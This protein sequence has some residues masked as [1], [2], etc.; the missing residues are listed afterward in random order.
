MRSPAAADQ[1]SFCST[2]PVQES[3]GFAEDVDPGGHGYA[4][5]LDAEAEIVAQDGASNLQGAGDVV[6]KEQ[7]A[8]PAPTATAPGEICVARTVSVHEEDNVDANENNSEV[9]ARGAVCA[10]VDSGQTTNFSV[11]ENRNENVTGVTSRKHSKEQPEVEMKNRKQAERHASGSLEDAPPSSSESRTTRNCA[12]QAGLEREQ[13]QPAPAS[14]CALEEQE[15][16]AAG[17]DTIEYPPSNASSK[18]NT[19]ATAAGI[20]P[21]G[22]SGSSVLPAGTVSVQLEGGSLAQNLPAGE[23]TRIPQT[24]LFPPSPGRVAL[25]ARNECREEEDQTDRT[26]NTSREPPSASP[27][28]SH[29]A[30]RNSSRTNTYF[31]KACPQQQG[32]HQVSA[33]NA[34]AGGQGGW[35][36]LMRELKRHEN[37]LEPYL[38]NVAPP[39]PQVSCG[40]L[41]TMGGP[42]CKLAGSVAPGSMAISRKPLFSSNAKR[43]HMLGDYDHDH[44]NSRTTKAPRSPLLDPKLY[45]ENIILRSTLRVPPTSA[46]EQGTITHHVQAESAR[47]EDAEQSTDIIQEFLGEAAVERG[48]A[49]GSTSQQKIHARASDPAMKNNMQ[50]DDATARAPS[51]P[52]DANPNTSSKG[53]HS[54]ADVFKHAAIE[55]EGNDHDQRPLVPRLAAL[56]LQQQQQKRQSQSYSNMMLPARL[57]LGTSQAGRETEQLIAHGPSL[58][59]GENITLRVPGGAPP[60]GGEPIFIPDPIPEES[61]GERDWSPREQEGLDCSS[62]LSRSVNLLLLE[63]DSLSPQVGRDSQQLDRQHRGEFYHRTQN[64]NSPRHHR[65]ATN[66]FEDQTTQHQLPLGVKETSATASSTLLVT[67]TN[68]NE[69]R[70]DAALGTVMLSKEKE[71]SSSATTLQNLLPLLRNPAAL[72]LNPHDLRLPFTLR[73]KLFILDSPHDLPAAHSSSCSLYHEPEVVMSK[74]S[75]TRRTAAPSTSSVR[76]VNGNHG[77]EQM[78]SRPSHSVLSGSAS[79]E[80]VLERSNPHRHRAAASFSHQQWAAN[81]DSGAPTTLSSSRRPY[82]APEMVPSTPIVLEQQ[83]AGGRLV[84]LRQ[85]SEYHATSSAPLLSKQIG[86]ANDGTRTAEIDSSFTS[87]TQEHDNSK[88]GGEPAAEGHQTPHQEHNSDDLHVRKQRHRSEQ[89]PSGLQPCSSTIS[90]PQTKRKT[91]TVVQSCVM[92]DSGSQVQGIGKESGRQLQS[93]D[94]NDIHAADAH[95]SALPGAPPQQPQGQQKSDATYPTIGSAVHSADGNRRTRNSSSVRRARQLLS[96]ITSSTK[97]DYGKDR[98]GTTSNRRCVNNTSSADQHDARRPGALRK[99]HERR[100]TRQVAENR[101]AS[102]HRDRYEH[103]GRELISCRR[104]T[105][106]RGRRDSSSSSR[107]RSYSRASPD[108]SPYSSPA[109]SASSGGSSSTSSATSQSYCSSSSSRNGP[110]DD[111]VIEERRPTGTGAATNRGNGNHKGRRTD[112]LL[113]R[114]LHSPT[115]TKKKRTSCDGTPAGGTTT[116]PISGGVSVAE[117]TRGFEQD[118]DQQGVLADQEEDFARPDYVA[119]DTLDDLEVET[120]KDTVAATL[121]EVSNIYEEQRR[122]W[123][124][125]PSTS[126]RPAS[127]RATTRLLPPAGAVSSTCGPPATAKRNSK[128]SAVAARHG[129]QDSTLEASSFDDIP[130]RVVRSAAASSK[131]YRS[132]DRWASSTW[133]DVGRAKFMEG[134]HQAASPDDEQEDFFED[135]KTVDCFYHRPKT[136]LTAS[137]SGSSSS[138]CRK[139]TARSSAVATRARPEAAVLEVLLPRGARL[140]EEF[141]VPVPSRWDSRQSTFGFFVAETDISEQDAVHVKTVVLPPPEN[142]AADNRACSTSTGKSNFFQD[143]LQ[144]PVPARYED[145]EETIPN[146]NKI[147]FKGSISAEGDVVASVRGKEAHLFNLKEIFEAA[148]STSL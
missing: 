35:E 13:P 141:V 66:N 75:T 48:R 38:E 103:R 64:L 78:L 39:G 88:A 63:A 110:E 30:G 20:C 96:S 111:I 3:F 93:Y 116:T 16:A 12:Q 101:T 68:T 142:G 92:P 81:Q 76:L 86:I 59:P 91:P 33:A 112:L 53:Y 58:L 28:E 74:T 95:E 6:V 127:H 83:H 18:T 87:Y 136:V 55:Q 134:L 90:V 147:V 4:H 49:E 50:E 119:A 69:L 56:S 10:A 40:T 118:E 117:F 36:S 129:E 108:A 131:N 11:E 23:N 124:H 106:R 70:S 139:N 98:S 100:S 8:A 47:S 84:P 120:D 45:I 51:N 123:Y 115:R 71:P 14:A 61:A 44:I 25:A 140:G 22:S 89:H 46:R 97:R 138:A 79:Q 21:S 65:E 107:N 29:V 94:R 62:Q 148:R 57:P 41:G 1:S 7:C 121:S 109:S 113:E 26:R 102:L 24:T 82:H 137:A 126:S 54:A 85:Q 114:R 37:D 32:L 77:G 19:G 27:V 31:K 73:I 43:T 143:A 125:T 128:A 42:G 2:I 15:R 80:G 144:G 52:A 99:T 132:D 72:A 9:P 34:G 105:A 122:R 17:S 146:D 130:Q 145:H 60:A 135:E 67:T 133:V 5:R 104:S